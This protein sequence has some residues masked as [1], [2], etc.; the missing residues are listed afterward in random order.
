MGVMNQRAARSTTVVVASGPAEERGW[1][2]LRTALALG[3]AGHRITVHL[4]GA[5]A[6]WAGRLDARDWLGG[7]PRADL[8][9]L[10]DDVG[11]TVL[12]EAPED[13]LRR[14]G[15]VSVAPGDARSLDEAGDVLV[16]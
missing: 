5:G 7:D 6:L 4:T 10:L 1:L 11:A 9:G 8:D 12:V 13:R 2:G 14:A 15:M 3:L 16:F